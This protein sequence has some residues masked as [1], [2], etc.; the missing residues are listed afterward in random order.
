MLGGLG[1]KGNNACI[2][3]YCDNVWPA[4]SLKRCR[5]TRANSQKAQLGQASLLQ[6]M[7]PLLAQSGYHDRAELCP[8]LGV[9]RT[10]TFDPERALT[11]VD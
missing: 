4:E 5:L 10:Y 3:C 7:S 9:K 2:S 11:S 1:A 6:C 8:L